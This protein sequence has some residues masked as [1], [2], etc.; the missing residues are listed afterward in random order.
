MGA[1]SRSTHMPLAWLPTL[2]LILLT[3]VALTAASLPSAAPAMRRTWFASIMLFGVLALAGSVWQGMKAGD[4]APRLTG[5][6]ASAENLGETKT[7]RAQLA[8]R[9]E[10]L[11]KRVREL[12]TGGAGRTV[13]ADTAAKFADYLRGFGSHRVVVSCTPDDLEAYDYANQLV[14]IL[15]AANWDAEGPEITEIFGDVRAIGVNLYINGDSHTDTVKILLDGFA[16]FNIPYQS[17][18]TPSQAIP[19]TETVELFVAALPSPSPTAKASS[20]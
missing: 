13:S 9:I 5:T 17:R 20:D 12:E 10:K 6:T 1:V 18:V 2:L 11:E 7:S 8:E 15:K 19:D 4:A 3:A 14:N 16:K